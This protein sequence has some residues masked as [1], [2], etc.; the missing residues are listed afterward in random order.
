VREPYPENIYE[1]IETNVG[2]LLARLL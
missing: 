2:N 1:R